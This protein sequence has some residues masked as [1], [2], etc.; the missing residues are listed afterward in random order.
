MLLLKK[1]LVH[2]SYDEEISSLCRKSGRVDSNADILEL[3][4]FSSSTRMGCKLNALKR[5]SGRATRRNVELDEYEAVIIACEEWMGAVP[6]PVSSFIENS[7]LRYKNVICIVFGNGAFAKKAEDYLRV[8]VSL[9]GGTVQNAIT[10]PV[11]TLKTCDEDIL[12][13]VRHKLAV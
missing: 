2:C 11:K 6:S 1:L 7:N 12:F 9:S 13:Y 8:K 5:K 10:V 4:E 3:R